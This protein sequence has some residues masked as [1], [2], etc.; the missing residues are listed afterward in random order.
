MAVTDWTKADTER[1]Q[2]I[3]DEYVAEHDLSDRKGQAAGIDPDS[4]H[5]WF[6]ESALDIVDQMDAA[7][8]FRPLFFVRVGSP[9]YL[10][11]G[12]RR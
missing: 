4:G 1:A 2:S 5:I 12:G 9:S 11:K 10:R 3:W 7:N 8:E 6:G